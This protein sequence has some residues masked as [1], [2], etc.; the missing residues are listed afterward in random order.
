MTGIK[1]M[2]RFSVVYHERGANLF[3][4]NLHVLKM[5]VKHFSVAREGIMGGGDEREREG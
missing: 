1:M 2:L 5:S 3:P 4:R